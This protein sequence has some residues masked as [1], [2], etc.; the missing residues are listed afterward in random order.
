MKKVYLLAATAAISLMTSL[1][2]FAQ[3][4][5][6]QPSAQNPP[7]QNPPA[8]GPSEQNVEELSRKLVEL[9]KEVQTLRQSIKQLEEQ[10]KRKQ[11]EEQQKREARQ[12][13]RTSSTQ[14]AVAAGAQGSG[15]RQRP[16]SGL[17]KQETVSRDR[18]TVARI[19][20]QPLQPVPEACNSG[21]SMNEYWR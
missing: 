5:G 18:E 19:D 3:S 7:T 8:Q 11:L 13:P 17:A 12:E 20:N 16:I 4:G 1:A 6:Q 14:P 10:Q 15:G 21:T 2:A 9:E